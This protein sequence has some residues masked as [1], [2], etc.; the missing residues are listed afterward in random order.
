[1]G[2]T[3]VKKHICKVLSEI[4]KSSSFSCFDVLES[5]PNPGLYVNGIGII[6][7]PLSDRDAKTISKAS[8]TRQS[9]FGKGSQTL[10]DLSIRKSWQIDLQQFELRNPEF[11]SQIKDA[12][13]RIT[14]DLDITCGP[15]N[16][17]PQLYKLL[18]YEEGAFFLPHQDS[19]KAQNMFGTLTV[20]LP[21]K[22][23]GGDIHLSH[24]G[25]TRVF[26]SSESSEFNCSHV[27][28]YADV[29]N[30]VKPVTSGNRLLS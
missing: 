23:S 4:E 22:H 27:A 15:E 25:D 20:S 13:Q 12:V 16:V 30:K 9:P 21:S 1:M 6:G 26:Q 19:E 14:S 17:V 8:V 2:T 18:L 10:I 3:L 5:C 11:N 24:N 7:L 29:T 28:W